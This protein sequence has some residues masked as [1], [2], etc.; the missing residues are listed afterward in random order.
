MMPVIRMYHVGVDLIRYREQTPTGPQRRVRRLCTSR[1]TTAITTAQRRFW[2]AGRTSTWM[3][4]TP[5]VF[6]TSWVMSGVGGPLPTVVAHAPRVCHED[7]CP[8]CYPSGR[9]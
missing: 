5:P 4:G 2:A 1:A 9:F 7:V 6:G 8:C 3:P